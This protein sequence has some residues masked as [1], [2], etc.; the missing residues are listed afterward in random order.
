MDDLKVLTSADLPRLPKR[1]VDA[2][3]T[4]VGSVLVVAGSYGMAGAAYLTAISALR[5]GAGYVR[6]ATPKSVYPIL[7]TLVPSAV[8]IPLDCTDEQI[9]K[10]SEVDKVLKEADHAKVAVMGPGWG[11]RPEAAKLFYALME[12]LRIPKVLDANALGLLGRRR[13]LFAR[14]TPGDVLTPHPGEMGDLL[15]LTAADVQQ[16][17]LGSVTKLAELTGAVSVL[18]GAKT[19][20]C[21]G[22][23]LYRNTSGNAGM[24]KAGTGDVLSGV[25]GALMAQGLG[26]FDSAILGVYI[27]GKAGDAAAGRLGRGLT[28]D[29]VSAGIAGAIRRYERGRFEKGRD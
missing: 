24:A 22:K 29:D 3:K 16:D 21:D 20:V 27:H 23:R 4:S 6:V 7:A 18:K 9:V 5:A 13:D 10:A 15:G 2:F 14:L 26:S 17:R 11:D 12:D 8:F 1:P 25:V 19:L 28:A